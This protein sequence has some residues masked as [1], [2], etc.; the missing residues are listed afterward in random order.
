MLQERCADLFA[1][2]RRGRSVSLSL[3][4]AAVGGVL[5]RVILRLAGG[6]TGSL[7]ALVLLVVFAPLAAYQVIAARR[8]LH[9]AACLPLSDPAQRPIW[10]GRAE[11][12][13][14]TAVTL[15]RL[16]VAVDFVRRGK[17]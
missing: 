14:P 17:H 11:Y 10:H 1:A 9:H 15:Y 12:A 4:V 3:F 6:N 7:M 16:A 2:T 5:G 13:A 8:R